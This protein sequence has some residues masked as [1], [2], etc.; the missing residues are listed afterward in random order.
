MT[1]ILEIYLPSIP[2]CGE[3]WEEGHL[4]TVLVGAYL[5]Q[6]PSGYMF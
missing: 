5:V 1:S 2:K 4:Q 6:D 3:V